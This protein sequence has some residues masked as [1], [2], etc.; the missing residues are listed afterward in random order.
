M[1]RFVLVAML[2]AA[3]VAHADPPGLTPVL[4]D[5][6]Y[7]LQ[8]ALVDASV[9]GLGLMASKANEPE[10]D[11]IG[12]AAVAT[13]AFGAPLLHLYHRHP[14]RAAASFA[15]R[16][17]LPL[18][19]M[20]IGSGIGQRSCSEGCDNNTDIIGAAVGALIGSIAASAIDIGY[21]SRGEEPSEPAP[22]LAPSF[23]AGANGTVRLGIGGSF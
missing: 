7:R 16:V 22:G 21:L 15:L 17:G 3:R 1:V 5:G 12:D 11:K 4:D 19:G 23:G 6:S 9:I 2:I 13:F 18:L 20:G 14:G 10:S 8:T